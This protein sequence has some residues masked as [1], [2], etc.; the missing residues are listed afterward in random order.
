MLICFTDLDG[1]LLNHNDYR[2]DAAIPVIRQLQAA[3]VPIIP[4][5]SKTRSEVIGLRSALGLMDPFIVENGSGVFLEPT[6]Q[7]FEFADEYRTVDGLKLI[8]LGVTYDVARAGLQTIAAEIG[9][10]LSGFADL[11]IAELAA[12]T[13]LAPADLRQACDRE[14]SEPFL[15]PQTALSTLEAI[16]GNHQF[17]VLVG[18]RFCHLLGA[19]ASKGR[20]VALLAAAWCK[21]H[22]DD[23]PPVILGLGDSPND[24]SM[25]DAVNIAIVIPGR[26]GPHPD[27]AARSGYRIAP[28]V[29]C[30]GWAAAVTEV[31]QSLDIGCPTAI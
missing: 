20:A 19:G 16:A 6:D 25:L 3:G 4:T 30:Q 26:D 21:A 8:Q 18:N 29:G 23:C 7:R 12:L 5:T 27:L 15:R 11:G 22:G 10:P 24:I 2:Y 31:M 28:Y 1:T 14:F 17:K 13:N 9:E